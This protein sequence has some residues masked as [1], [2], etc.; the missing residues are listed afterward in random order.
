MF[1]GTNRLHTL[2]S[3][4]MVDRQTDTA[5][6]GIVTNL[7][8]HRKYIMFFVRTVTHASITGITAH[9]I[10]IKKFTATQYSNPTGRNVSGRA[11]HVNVLHIV[12]LLLDNSA[13]VSGGAGEVQDK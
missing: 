4:Q 8:F 2:C 12:F 7:L 5:I 1:A 6:T 9:A 13:E 11:V 10:M 3:R